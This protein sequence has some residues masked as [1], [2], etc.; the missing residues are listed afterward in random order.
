FQALDL[1]LNKTYTEAADGTIVDNGNA[2]TLPTFNLIATLFPGRY[3]NITTYLNDAEFIVDPLTGLV[4]FD[5]PAWEVE[6]FKSGLTMLRAT[7]SD[8]VSFDISA[9]NSSD[10]PSL[11]ATGAHADKF[12]VTGDQT[13]IAKGYGS[14]GSFDL[15]DEGFITSG[16]LTNSIVIGGVGGSDTA[17]GTYNVTEPDPRLL[18]PDVALLSAVQG[19]WRPIDKVT[20]GLTG[21]NFMIF[22]SSAI[23]PMT[24][25]KSPDQAVAFNLNAAGKVTSLWF[26]TVSM[27]S[28]SAG[29]FKMYPVKYAA[30]LDKT[31]VP[32]VTG[33]VKVTKTFT[34]TPLDKKGTPVT[35]LGSPISN[36][37]AL[38]GTFAAAGAPASWT[39]GASG[40]FMVFR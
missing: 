24:G 18:P 17:N 35:F 28:A 14:T 3:T 2:P 32:S 39:Y 22:P 9:L 11:S 20:S 19:I 7:L 23:D 15:I 30:T 16:V 38:G 6:N 25:Q 4:T 8:F 29:T 10:V 1:V 33:T 12:M 40:T 31:G 27:T 21:N 37:S 13:G 5:E 26:G 36:T 34:W